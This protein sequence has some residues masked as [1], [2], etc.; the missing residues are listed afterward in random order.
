MHHS[1][2]TDHSI[3]HLRP[4]FTS[5]NRTLNFLRFTALM[6]DVPLQST[7]K[8]IMPITVRTLV[9]VVVVFLIT[10]YWW[11][12]SSAEIPDVPSYRWGYFEPFV[13]VGTCVIPLVTFC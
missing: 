2:M 9:I 3:P 10:G 6:Y 8:F 4:V 13:T 12:F 7:K 11:W 5:Q 1:T